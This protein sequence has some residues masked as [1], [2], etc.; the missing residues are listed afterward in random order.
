MNSNDAILKTVAAFVGV[1]FSAIVVFWG[2]VTVWA[3]E[4]FLP[5]VGKYLPM[6]RE[7]VAN[8]FE[9]IDDKVA[10]PMRRVFKAAWKKIRQFLL[11]TAI[12]F[13]RT[14]S[15][16][17]VRK[18]TSYVIKN[19]ES[20]QVVKQTVEEEIPWD[21]LTPDIRKSWMRSN[22][23]NVEIDYTDLKDKNADSDLLE[24]FN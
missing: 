15:N 14:S 5:F 21:D 20:K 19:L 13:Q 16:K 17:W 9:W 1:A 10:V 3:K 4:S 8:A 24:L 6:L 11:K 7:D 12:D 18:T 22:K 2:K 23:D